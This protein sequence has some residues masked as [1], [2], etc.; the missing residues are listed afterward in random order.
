MTTEPAGRSLAGRVALVTGAAG[1]IGRAVSARFAAAGA[2]VALAGRTA[3]DLEDV[4]H[5]IDADAADVLV[6]TAD[7]TRE[8][9]VN[10]LIRAIETRWAGLDIVVNCAGINVRERSL[11]DVSVADW[12]R[13]T[14]VNVLGPLLVSRAAIALM[15]RRAAGRIVLVSSTAGL[16]A[17]LLSGPAY[18]ASKAAL[19]SLATSIN[20]SERHHGIG[21]TLI[22]PGDVSTPLLDRWPE[23]PSADAR[24]RMLQPE[25]VA[26]VTLAAVALPASALV[27]LVVVRPLDLPGIAP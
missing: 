22:C 15:R 3:A 17:T 6:T 25:D 12:E 4:A 8:Q 9:D 23:P 2:R 27:E 19:N 5:E 10:D 18:S 26:A 7:V 21:A 20:L 1:G 11:E 14:A 24:A 13:I 16:A